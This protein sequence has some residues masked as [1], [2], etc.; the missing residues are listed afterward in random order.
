LIAKLQEAIWKYYAD[1]TQN[2]KGSITGTHTMGVADNTVKVNLKDFIAQ[3]PDLP[4]STIDNGLLNSITEL[5]VSFSGTTGFSTTAPGSYPLSSDFVATNI[6]EEAVTKFYEAGTTA[7]GY[8]TYTLLTNPDTS[9]VTALK[10]TYDDDGTTKTDYVFSDADGN[11]L[12]D[13]NTSLYDEYVKV[14]QK[15]TV[16]QTNSYTTQESKDIYKDEPGKYVLS[17]LDITD[18]D[19][20]EVD[21]LITFLNNNTTS[22]NIA[23]SSDDGSFQYVGDNGNDSFNLALSSLGTNFSNVSFD[24]SNTSNVNNNVKSTISGL[25]DDGRMVG[26]LTGVS[27]GTDGVITASYDN[28]MQKNIAQISVATFEN[29]MGLENAGDNLYTATSNSGEFNGV[30]VDIKGSGTGYMTTGV[31]EMSNVD[32]STEFTNMITTQRGFQANSRIITT[33]DTLLE[34]LVNLKR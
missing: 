8:T 19:G 13:I 29:S 4:T 16:T 27:I 5:T 32:L 30:G 17:L 24:M 9:K 20:N 12:D 3:D 26:N 7:N 1:D 28:G 21:G 6:K 31:L 25:R 14:L 11:E 2:A 10:Q 22:W 23:Y 33:S 34:E 18:S 15:G